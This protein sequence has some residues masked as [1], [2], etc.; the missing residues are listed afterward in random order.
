MKKLLK[1]RGLRSTDLMRAWDNTADGRLTRPEFLRNM[2]VFV[3]DEDLW[4]GEMKDVARSTFARIDTSND[5][6]VTILELQRWLEELPDSAMSYGFLMDATSAPQS[7]A[8]M[9]RQSGVGA[10]GLLGT[11][12]EPP[13]TPATPTKL[14]IVYRPRFYSPPRTSQVVKTPRAKRSYELST[15]NW[16]HAELQQRAARA[17]SG[18][19]PPGWSS[20]QAPS[21]RPSKS[22]SPRSPSRHG[23]PNGPGKTMSTSAVG[24][25]LLSP[26]V[27][28]FTKR[29][30]SARLPTARGALRTAV[31]LGAS[32]GPRVMSST[33]GGGSYSWA[34]QLSSPRATETAGMIHDSHA[35]WTQQLGAYSSALHHSVGPLRSRCDK[36]CN[37]HVEVQSQL[38]E[39]PMATAP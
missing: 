9:R 33:H 3:D 5:G 29:P 35:R 10:H 21:P 39:E 18:H 31:A 19:K 13:A 7:G 22:A 15:P 37:P 26:P 6:Y 32:H 8:M 36:L 27:T 11:S 1:S 16:L 25:P 24:N 34:A 28:S 38:R 4:Y 20:S 14:K 2:K 30:H 17:R 23:V 12:N